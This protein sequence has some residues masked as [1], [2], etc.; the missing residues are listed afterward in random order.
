MT[1]V[2]T[3][4][5]N[6]ALDLSTTVEEVLPFRKLRSGTVRR[7]PGG[8]GI[9]AARVVNRLGG[10]AIAVY[11]VGGPAGQLLQQLVDAQGVVSRVV[12]IGGDTRED[13]SV[14]ETRTGRQFRFV[15]PG[16]KLAEAEWR[17]CLAVFEQ[18]CEESG[19]A[20]VSGSL[21]PGVPDD[22]FFG[23]VARVAK[24]RRTK[25]TV[26]TTGAGLQAALREGVFLIK[27]NQNEFADL[28]GLRA[29]DMH[30]MIAAARNLIAAG[31]IEA[32]ALSL[33]D[34]GAVLVTRERS[35]RARAPHVDVL[36]TVGAGDSFLGAMVWSL[37]EGHAWQEALRLAVAAG[38]AALLSP[39]TDLAQA[40]EV[41]RL[42][43]EVVV[44]DVA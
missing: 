34:E 36:S 37:A 5:M 17:A 27:P 16:P 38:S 20:I 2:I 3:L 43:G 44:E 26:D 11:P 10:K 13:F 42:S 39:G 31:R 18:L 32:I 40:Q 33:A 6:P 14:F 23:A 28:V 12:P 1:S 15:T 8:G 35:W 4:T 7:D 22:D 24:A 21:P 9:N 19:Y 30:A 41:H 25:L 29:P